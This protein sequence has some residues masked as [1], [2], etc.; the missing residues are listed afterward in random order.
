[1]QG[2]EPENIEEIKSRIVGPS[3]RLFKDFD[4][5]YYELKLSLATTIN[6]RHKELLNHF[7]DA[8][9]QASSFLHGELDESFFETRK[10]IMDSFD[11]AMASGNGDKLPSCIC[12]ID[13]E[14][15]KCL[16]KFDEWFYHD[17]SIEK[18]QA[19]EDT[20]IPRTDSML[21]EVEKYLKLN[22]RVFLV[23]GAAHVLK[24]KESHALTISKVHETFKKFRYLI[25]CSKA[26]EKRLSAIKLNPDLDY[27]PDFFITAPKSLPVL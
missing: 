2:W 7:L 17:P 21:Q 20:F 14:Y 16:E 22:R 9:N 23:T 25:L 8:L 19:L 15:Q 1:M 6:E 12:M 27:R 26:I 11:D 24:D 5:A 18:N 10:L 13:K 4:D 3:Y